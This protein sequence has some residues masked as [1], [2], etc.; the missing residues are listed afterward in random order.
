MERNTRSSNAFQNVFDDVIERIAA[1]ER[2]VLS[3]ASRF[4]VRFGRFAPVVLALGLAVLGVGSSFAAA[5][6]TFEDLVMERV[7]EERWDNGQLPPLAR[8][9]L[10]DQST[11]LHSQNMAVRNFFAHCDPDELTSPWDRMV[12]AGYDWDAAGENISA[13]YSTPDAVMDG[14]MSSAGHR[15]NIL[16]NAFRELGIGHVHATSDLGGVRLDGNGDCVSEGSSGPFFHYWTQNFG[17]RNDVFPIVIDREA[18]ST[19]SRDVALYIYGVGWASEMRLRNDAGA[20]SGWTP[21]ATNVAW[22]LSASDGAKI[23]AVEL[24]SGAVVRASSDEIE[25]TGQPT[26]AAPESGMLD[27]TLRIE[28]VAPSPFASEG[29]RIRFELF[30]ATDVRLSVHDASGREV[31]TLAVGLRAAGHYDLAWRPDAARHPHGAYF[32]RLSTA[33]GSVSRKVLFVD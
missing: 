30:R 26:S 24:R 3:L 1:R 15:A 25:L 32:V 6:P 22:Q 8:E 19:D 28:S 7:N 11:E 5:M 2:E 4:L 9:G 20:W 23:V 14:W 27:G 10:L 21:F 33:H 12:A 16:S 29:T 17:R 18:F 13:G 31:D